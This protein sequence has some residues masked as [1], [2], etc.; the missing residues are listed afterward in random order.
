MARFLFVF[1]GLF[2]LLAP[3]SAQREPRG[4]EPGWRDLPLDTNPRAPRRPSPADQAG[5]SAEVPEKSGKK[6][7]QAVQ[8][9]TLE[10]LYDRLAKAQDAKEAGVIA[11]QIERRWARSGSDTAD[12]L[13]SRANTAVNLKD[14]NTALEVFDHIILL[15]PDWAE[16]YHRRATLFFS[17]QDYDGA[18]RDLSMA[19]QKE[20][21]HFAALSGVGLVLQQLDR[22]KAALAAYKKALE[23][24]P[25]MEN[26]KDIVKRLEPEVDGMKL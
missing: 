3:A 17:M 15:K 25:N 23:L 13:L 19:L 8:P 1:I 2:A 12:L 26:L 14:H 9:T 18:L 20:P 11:K 10:S 21:R 22:K 16:A 24:H 6:R 4:G 5:P 7:P